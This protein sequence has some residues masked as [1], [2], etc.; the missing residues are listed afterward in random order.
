MVFAI[1]AR[2]IVVPIAGVAF[3]PDG[4]GVVIL[5][6]LLAR[7]E[8]VRERDH[9]RAGRGHARHPARH[10]V[11]LERR[12]LAVGVAAEAVEL[13]VIS[14]VVAGIVEAVVDLVLRVAVDVV[15]VR[16]ARLVHRAGVDAADD[17][18]QEAAVRV[19]DAPVRA[20]LAA[21]AVVPVF[22]SDVD[23]TLVAEAE[24]LVDVAG[25]GIAVAFVV[26]AAGR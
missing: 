3:K 26:L 18:G 17:R 8:T 25:T 13:E 11:V 21:E 4:E 23:E 16:E 19:G 12:G 20:T 6:E 7:T 22:Y 5:L 14:E 9:R 15:D 1:G 24:S 2:Q 10:P